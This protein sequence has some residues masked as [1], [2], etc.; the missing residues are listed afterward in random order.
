[1]LFG[2]RGG[3]IF[4]KIGVGVGIKVVSDIVDMGLYLTRFHPIKNT[5]GISK[6]YN[7]IFAKLWLGMAN[8]I[9]V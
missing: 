1:M 7:I 4:G 6:R 3:I 8:V 5:E 9:R 2:T